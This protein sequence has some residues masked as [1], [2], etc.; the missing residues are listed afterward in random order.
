[1]IVHRLIACRANNAAPFPYY[2]G[3]RHLPNQRS[4]PH[5][6][7]LAMSTSPP[8]ALRRFYL[9]SGEVGCTHPGGG[10]HKNTQPPL[11]HFSVDLS[12]AQSKHLSRGTA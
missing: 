3:L 5:R 2:C 10:S 7:A 4:P 9:P 12:V 6:G 11:M 8:C 1:M